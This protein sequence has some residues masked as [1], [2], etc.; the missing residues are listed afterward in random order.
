MLC[1]GCPLR[2]PPLP[3]STFTAA[4]GAALLPLL[5]P[6]RPCGFFSCA[7][8]ART[9]ASAA[10]NPAGMSRP[11]PLPLL[12][13]MRGTVHFRAPCTHAP[14][15]HAP[16]PLLPPPPS[17]TPAGHA[18][19]SRPPQPALRLRHVLVERRHGGRPAEASDAGGGGAGGHCSVGAAR[20]APSCACQPRR[21]CVVAGG[22]VLAAHRQAQ[23]GGGPFAG[24][25]LW[26]PVTSR[27]GGPVDDMEAWVVPPLACRPACL[28]PPLLSVCLE[29]GS[30]RLHLSS[31]ADGRFQAASF[32]SLLSVPSKPAC[33]STP[34][35][36]PRRPLPPP[37]AGTAASPFGCR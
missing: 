32:P 11:A 14:C 25:P 10:P 9:A 12:A 2:H 28:L 33:R 34:P 5:L 30:R 8:P 20:N 26:F 6:H 18:A 15:T 7:F 1:M 19:H 37:P 13:P 4:H 22:V 35:A 17:S 21:C 31:S 3:S 23:Q 16:L 29:R 36:C 27:Q 24:S